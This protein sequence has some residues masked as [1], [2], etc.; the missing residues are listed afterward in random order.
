[1]DLSN[2]QIRPVVL[3]VDDVATNVKILADA[4]RDEYRIKVA[5]NGADAL[6]T[7]RTEPR[8]D[9]I[10][11][12]IMMPEMDGYEVCRRLKNQPETS[13]IPVI[14]VTAKSTENDE[15]LGFSLGAI[16]Y[17]TKPFSIPVVK[18]RVRNHVTL[19]RQADQL[20][21]I[22]LLDALTQIP[23]RRYFDEALLRE[24]QS[25]ARQQQPISL[26]MIDID[27]FKAY[28][29][30]HGHSH[31]DQ[32]LRQVAHLL[33]GGLRQRQDI[34]ARYGG[35]EF[36]VILPATANQEAQQIAEELRQQVIGLQLHLGASNDAAPL[37]ISIG[38]ATTTASGNG[39]ALELLQLADQLLYRAK[40]NGRNR[41]CAGQLGQ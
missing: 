7:A 15:T 31:G 9:L 3:I 16:D 28:N 33:A 38:C 27:H 2:Q 30:C 14:F 21:Q 34:V 4:L 35:E 39:A 32:A 40:E 20:E 6:E 12:D 11:L 24:W 25:A 22:S 5:S 41:V 18:A 17:I 26:L 37:S 19:K 8:P 23:N 29:D 1:M 36:V 13:K 10:L